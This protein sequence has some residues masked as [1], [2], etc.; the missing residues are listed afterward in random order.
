MTI[1]ITELEKFL[2]FRK[3]DE[4]Y[5]KLVEGSVIEKID[6]E[7]FNFDP[8]I[9]ILW[10]P[11][12]TFNQVHSMIKEQIDAQKD[13]FMDDT[14]IV[15]AVF[16]MDNDGA[17]DYIV[18]SGSSFSYEDIMNGCIDMYQECHFNDDDKTLFEELR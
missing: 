4:V 8:D 7:E 6:F 16:R 17:Y 11:L 1:L 5:G 2:C 10:V 15:M 9:C 18:V 12:E 14:G 3:P 13:D